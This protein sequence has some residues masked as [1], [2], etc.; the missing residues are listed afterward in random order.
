MDRIVIEEFNHWWLS[1]KVD[2]DLALPFKRDCYYDVSEHMA[3]R[4]IIAIAGLRRTGKTTMIY[5]LIQ[6]L[7]SEGVDPTDVLFFSFDETSKG[8]VDVINTY[9]DIHG[10][11]LRARRVYI[12]LDEIQK[13]ENW[14]NEVKKYYDLYPKLKF[15]ISGSES[16]FIKKKTKE[17]LAGRVF[18]FIL[19]TFSFKEYLKFNDIKEKIPYETA[20]KPLLVKFVR[21][22]GFP[23]T[24]SLKNDTEFR[25]YIGA[26]AI[27]RIIYRDIPKIF[28][29]DDPEFL[30]TLLE[31]IATNPGMY[32]DYQ[33]LSRQFGKDRRVIKDYIFFLQESFLISMLGNYRKGNAATLRKRKR[34]YPTDN[35]IIYL[36][37]R[38]IDDA[39]FGRMVESA[40]INKAKAP[41]FWKNSNEIDMV[42][43][44]VPIEVKYQERIDKND[45]KPV[46]EFMKKFGKKEG[47]IITKKDESEEKVDCGRIKLIPLWKWLLDV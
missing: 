10:K 40:A 44:D 16:L 2:P 24:F 9:N 6:K 14:E 18:Q 46:E 1:G 33:S 26:L 12:F 21:M 38:D 8:L 15:I 25:E 32:V 37:K 28:K 41:T 11:N 3:D 22:G 17:T 43:E 20:L 42:C 36:Y 27:D 5:Q 23:E 7:I 13:S 47:V 34:A 29:I 19:R 35:A 45:L 31:L 4:F 39:F 30:K